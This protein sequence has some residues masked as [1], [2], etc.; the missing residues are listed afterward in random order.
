[1]PLAEAAVVSGQSGLS[2]EMDINW[3]AWRC[4]QTLECWWAWMAR[5]KR[6]LAKAWSVFICEHTQSNPGT[7]CYHCLSSFW[8]SD[9][10]CTWSGL[11]FAT[12]GWTNV[13]LRSQTWRWQWHVSIAEETMSDAW[14]NENDEGAFANLPECCQETRDETGAQ[15]GHA[16]C[17][18]AFSNQV[19]GRF[20]PVISKG[21]NPEWALQPAL[22]SVAQPLLGYLLRMSALMCNFFISPFSVAP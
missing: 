9:C 15:M 18:A 1:M 6:P 20:Q 21:S 3:A 2:A 17:E 4:F 7:I 14:R 10:P 5:R 19:R 22:S 16:L 12:L 8:P 11:I 13:E